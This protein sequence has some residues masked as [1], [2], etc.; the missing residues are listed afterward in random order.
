MIN[1]TLYYRF[2]ECDSNKKWFNRRKKINLQDVEGGA[3]ILKDGL[4][5]IDT[6]TDKD[7]ELLL[8]LLDKLKCRCN[9]V[10]TLH[11][12]HAIF[13]K[14]NDYYVKSD[15]KYE[16]V[17]GIIVDVKQGRKSVI[18]SD[19]DIVKR[20]GKE[21]ETIQYCTID[22]L[23]ELP[24]Q[25]RVFNSRLNLQQAQEGSGRHSIHQR[26]LG[27]WQ[28]YV[29]SDA[30]EALRW[31]QWVN[32][33]VFAVPRE[34]VNWKLNNVQDWYDAHPVMGLQE[35]KTLSDVISLLNDIDSREMNKIY[36]YVCTNFDRGG[37]NND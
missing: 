19:I 5:M 35:P 23:D 9:I 27:R 29:N 12:I 7:S 33:Y 6:D 3:G 25:L 28:E 15:S 17:T 18:N 11:G 13:K 20:Y 10:S 1:D 21:M 14:P 2:I 4:I 8:L 34:S 36:S 37:D 30:K 16:T 24:W 31:V 32:D 22:E 26:L